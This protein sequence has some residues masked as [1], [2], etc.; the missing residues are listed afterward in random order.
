MQII[1]RA[2]FIT[3]FYGGKPY[4]TGTEVVK[5]WLE[6]QHDRLLNPKMKELKDALGNENKLVQYTIH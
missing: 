5:N 4:L 1:K 6:S 3:D 2:Q